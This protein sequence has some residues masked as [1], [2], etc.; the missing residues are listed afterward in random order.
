V[1]RDFRD[2]PSFLD[3]AEG[4]TGPGAAERPLDAD[5]GDGLPFQYTPLKEQGGD[6]SNKEPDPDAPRLARTVEEDKVSKHTQ[7]QAKPG[8]TQAWNPDP[9][10]CSQEQ[11][12]QTEHTKGTEDP[13]GAPH[14]SETTNHQ[15][16][17]SDARGD[18]RERA[19]APEIEQQP[20]R[21]RGS[22]PRIVGS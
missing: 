21:H 15:P 20:V 19:H 16:T 9:E 13:A 2:R 14:T 17:H 6:A 11:P 4:V 5:L 8:N 22:P 7:E 1:F 12:D 3:Q 18:L 10:G